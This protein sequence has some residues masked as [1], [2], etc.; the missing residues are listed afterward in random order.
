MAE[1]INFN[2]SINR[3]TVVY[4]NIPLYYRVEIPQV[5]ESL[6]QAWQHPFA[7]KVRSGV[8]NATVAS[9]V[10]LNPLGKDWYWRA[11]AT[12]GVVESFLLINAD[13]NDRIRDI[14]IKAGINLL[15]TQVARF[16][17]RYAP[18]ARL[19]NI[20]K[21]ISAGGAFGSI[22]RAGQLIVGNMLGTSLMDVVRPDGVIGKQFDKFGTWLNHNWLERARGMSIPD[23]T[24]TSP[25]P[26]FTPEPTTIPNTPTV[27]RPTVTVEP[28][29]TPQLSVEDKV[30]SLWTNTSVIGTNGD[31]LQA[32][33]GEKLQFQD[34]LI[35]KAM[36]VQG[37]SFHEL[38]PQAQAAARQAIKQALEDRANKSADQAFG[39]LVKQNPAL[40]INNPGL[41]NTA[42]AATKQTFDNW[43]N[44]SKN[45]AD[46]MGVAQKA[47]NEAMATPPVIPP[48]SINPNIPSPVDFGSKAAKFFIENQG[49]PELFTS[50]TVTWGETA[51]HLIQKMGISPTWDGSDWQAFAALKALNYQ[52]FTELSRA[53]N[54]STD[55]FAKLLT[56]IQRG[57]KDAYQALIKYM[58]RIEAGKQ[59]RLLSTEGM[60][61]LL[62]NS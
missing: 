5:P 4:Q 3:K 28:T 7:T 15:I 54:I 33:V 51:G 61:R 58:G 53:M 10:N 27:P 38:T 1:K 52:E 46:L 31:L 56:E 37:L 24:P 41:I 30:R 25:R 36:R 49:S 23:A 22:G 43:F 8:Q 14:L 18:D 44:D 62:V 6:K 55:E 45:Q 16:A 60:R 48:I 39:T 34:A 9:I 11:G 20:G 50:H 2:S 32:Y 26:T 19:E 17:A 42:K 13:P 47:A 35:D 59:I 29:A 57:N 21:G 40:D 12:I